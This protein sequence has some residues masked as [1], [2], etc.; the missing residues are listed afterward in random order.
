[1]LLDGACD[2]GFIVPGACPRALR[3]VALPPDPVVAVVA[4]AHP[5]AGRTATFDDLARQRVALNR[6]GSGAVE[7]VARLRSAGVPERV[8]PSVPMRSPPC[9]WP[10]TTATSPW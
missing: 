9:T 2:V 1:M 7:F 4:P 8:G 10:R 6:F 3:F 5:L